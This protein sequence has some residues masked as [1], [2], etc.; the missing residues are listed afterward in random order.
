M[1][2]NNILKSELIDIIFDG[3]NKEYGA[4]ELRNNY[5]KRIRNSMLITGVV[6]LGLIGGSVMA[7]SSRGHLATRDS[8][9]GVILT[10]IIEKKVEPPMPEPEKI[11]VEEPQVKSEIFTAPKILEDDKVIN[12]PPAMADLD[13]AKIDLVKREGVPDDRKPVIDV[14]DGKG[15]IEVKKHIEP[16]VH[17]TVD[18]DAKYNGNW[19]QYLERNLTPDVPVN[20]GAAPG[21]YSVEVKFVVDVEGHVSDIVALTKHGFG[22]EDEAIRV[23]RKSAKWEPAV[24]E[25]RMVKAY[26][27]QM[28]TFVVEGDE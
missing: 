4:Y 13:S 7:N 20:N 9:D 6:V 19:R 14:P 2:S 27:R 28:I 5:S 1:K 22:M 16:E 26:R 3:R 11:K 25:G 18:L 15:I 8:N 23:I 12:P 21:R 10:Q 24:F 17:V